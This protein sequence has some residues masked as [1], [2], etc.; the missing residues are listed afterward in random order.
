[1]LAGLLLGAAVSVIGWFAAR[2]VLVRAVVALR[3]TPLRPLLTNAPP[4]TAP[5]SAG[6]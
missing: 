2:T 5:S 4:A 3:H 6:S 1:V